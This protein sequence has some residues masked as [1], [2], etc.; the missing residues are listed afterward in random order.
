M[1]PVA[2]YAQ[3]NGRQ[4]GRRWQ[5]SAFQRDI[6]P[7]PRTMLLSRSGTTGPHLP[8]GH[9]PGYPSRGP[10][11]SRC[12]RAAR[13]HGKGSNAC[14]LP[15]D[16]KEIRS[17]GKGQKKQQAVYVPACA[18]HRFRPDP[19]ETRGLLAPQRT[20]QETT[21]LR[22]CFYC[23]CRIRKRNRNKVRIRSRYGTG[24]PEKPDAKPATGCF[25]FRYMPI[26]PARAVPPRILPS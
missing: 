20:D 18:P 2:W 1:S 13:D 19:S 14:E 15:V 23:V 3:V 24:G 8:R 21:V 22:D 16:L 11:P 4:H 5:R 9:P 12:C 25:F 26:P 10:P 6:H 7:S 17:R